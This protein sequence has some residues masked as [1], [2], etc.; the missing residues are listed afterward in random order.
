M[1]S[2][3]LRPARLPDERRFYVGMAIVLLAIVLAGFSRSFFLRPLFPDHPSP[4]ETV[5][6]WHGAVFTAWFLLLVAQTTLIATGRVAVHRALG[7]AGGVLAAAMVVLGCF[8]ALVAGARKGGFIDVPIPPLSFLIVP[9]ADML[10]FG[11]LVGVAIAKR[12]V[13]Q[14]HKRLMLIASIS[15]VAAAVARLPFDFLATGGPIV[16]FG[17]QDLLL[18]VIVIWDFASRGRPHPA[19][20]WGSALLIASQPIRL[21]VSGTET[22]LAFAA[23]AV[24]IVS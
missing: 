11:V 10:I 4:P 5:F 7:R 19:T 20:L 1:T 16:F 18:V 22:W 3:T 6:Y 24:G 15:I 2:I 9:L 12:H 13:A 14:I 8:V 17:V 21:W 23:W